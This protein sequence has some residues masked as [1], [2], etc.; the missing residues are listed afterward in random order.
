[1]LFNVVIRATI[2][3]TI[4]V[5]ADSE[6]A[7]CESAHQEFTIECEDGDE[8]YEQDTMSLSIADS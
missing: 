2:T 1:M 8:R 3:K 7:A 4:Q 5:E 6:D